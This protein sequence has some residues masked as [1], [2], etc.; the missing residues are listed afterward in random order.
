MSFH[1]ELR[2]TADRAEA[3]VMVAM[4]NCLNPRNTGF[5]GRQIP[6]EKSIIVFDQALAKQEEYSGEAGFLRTISGFVRKKS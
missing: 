4:G 2:D 5:K 6:I 1:K 3:V